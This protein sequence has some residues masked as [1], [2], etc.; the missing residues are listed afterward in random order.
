MKQVILSFRKQ[1]QAPAGSSR[2][3]QQLLTFFRIILVVLTSGFFTPSL[4]AETQNLWTTGKIHV[5][6]TVLGTILILIFVF[7]IVLE[8]K[9]SRLERD[10]RH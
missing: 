6:L 4:A 1:R 8:R 9:I 7:L 10:F 5:V 3:R 2:I